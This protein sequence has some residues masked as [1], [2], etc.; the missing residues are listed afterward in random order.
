MAASKKKE[1][2]PPRQ[3]ADLAAALKGAEPARLYVLRGE[4]RYFREKAIALVRARAEALGWE[5]SSHATTDPDFDLSRL[6]GDL[7]GG[8]LFASARC[9]IVRDAGPLLTKDGKKDSAFVRAVLA[10]LDGTELDGCVVVAADSVRADSAIAKAA[11]RSGGVVVGCRRLWDSAPPWNPDP[12]RA[13]LV[14][15]LTA[16]AREKGV[17]L[18]PEQAMYVAAATGNDLFALESQL[19]KIAV[20]GESALREVV[21][22][23][24]AGSPYRVADSIVNGDV[25]RA[26]SSIE[27]L[28]RGGF[29]EKRGTRLVDDAALSNI[30]LSSV[31]R[32]VRQSMAGAL[33]ARAGG[34]PAEGARKAGWRIPPTA[35]GPFGEQVRRRPAAE[36]R[37]MLED[38]A[39]LELSARTGRPLD[40]NDFCHL[41]LRWRPRRAAG[42]ARAPR[43]TGS[44]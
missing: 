2:D 1:P 7:G 33:E 25:G 27:A 32:Q 38:A 31:V 5:V 20:S 29:Q 18:T 3:L 30:L 6:T 8:S 13:E 19:D 44:R 41:A 40:A 22:W 35:R 26:A 10:F 34:D 14:L 23:D 24:A 37:R 36:W 9:V 15:W 4:E 39:E 21:G 42:P 17:R 12:R 16:L 43:A 28:F 11:G